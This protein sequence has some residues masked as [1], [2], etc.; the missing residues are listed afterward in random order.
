M[1]QIKIKLNL[2]AA[3][4]LRLPILNG[5]LQLTEEEC[6]CQ[7]LRIKRLLDTKD[8]LLDVDNP[9]HLTQAFP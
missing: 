1:E 3:L 5:K 7:Y 9:L 2:I 8:E 6:M 4:M